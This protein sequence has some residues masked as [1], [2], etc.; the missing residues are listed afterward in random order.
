MSKQQQ[1]QRCS[2]IS[3]YDMTEVNAAN[4]QRGDM[5]RQ[6][7]RLKASVSTATL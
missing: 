4:E 1:Q 2:T 5:P 7:I 6:K 3:Y